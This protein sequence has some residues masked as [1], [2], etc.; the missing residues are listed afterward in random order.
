MHVGYVKPFASPP[1]GRSRAAAPSRRD[2]G[3]SFLRLGS[4]RRRTSASVG[5]NDVEQGMTGGCRAP[6]TE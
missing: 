2:K 5:R 4:D 6:M 1:A 3:R